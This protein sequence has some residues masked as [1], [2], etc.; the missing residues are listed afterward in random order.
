MRSFA[1][2]GT[3]LGFAVAVLVASWSWSASAVWAETT[4]GQTGDG[5]A[6]ADY[7]V[8]Y[9]TDAKLNISIDGRLDEA[10][11]EKIQPF[12]DHRVLEPETLQIPPLKTK[13]HITHSER[14]LYVG[15]KLFQPP[16][17]NYRRLTNRDSRINRDEVHI[18]IDNSGSGLYGHWFSIALGDSL[19]DGTVLPERNFYHEWDAVWRG[20]SVKTD[21]G[22]SA[23]MFIPWNLIPAAVTENGIARM[24]FYTS[25]KVGYLDERYGFPGLSTI[26]P[27]FM[28]ALQGIRLR[29]PTTR[30]GISLQPFV[31]AETE[32]VS[33]Q[34]RLR[35][36][37]D[38]HWRP[39]RNL[40]LSASV[41]PDFGTTDSDDVVLNLGALETFFSEQRQF[42]LEGR[43]IFFT[44]PRVRG[45][46]QARSRFLLVNT[47]RI[48]APVYR[49]ELAESGF[50][51]SQFDLVTPTDLYG[52]VRINGQSGDFRYGVLSAFEKTR[53][54][55]LAPTSS[56]EPA[57]QIRQQGQTFSAARGVYE[58]KTSD[59][60]KALGLFATNVTG[61]GREALVAGLDVHLLSK[62][63]ARSLD[64][65]FAYSDTK[66]TTDFDSP[67]DEGK[68][69]AMTVDFQHV[70]MPGFKHSLHAEYFSRNFELNDLGYTRRN[71]QIGT[72]YYIEKN[73]P[74]YSRSEKIDSMKFIGRFRHD[75]NLDGQM[76][77]A[78]Y[79]FNFEIDA[80]N[81]SS[82]TTKFAF[83]PERWEDLLSEG[84]GV[85]RIKDRGFVELSWETDIRKRIIG[86]IE[87]S[88]SF[89]SLGGMSK[90]ISSGLKMRPTDNLNLEISATYRDRNNW[91]IHDGGRNFTTYNAGN[92]S[93]S[94]K[95]DIFINAR[96]QF[97]TSLNWVGVDATQ[98]RYYQTPDKAGYLLPVAIDPAAT[99]NR[100]FIVSELIWQ[101]KYRWEFAPLSEL[102]LVY[103]HLSDIDDSS[104]TRF[105]GLFNNAINQPIV[106]QFI[107]KVRYR[108]DG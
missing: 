70:P 83:F 81:T 53:D 91:L 94:F 69:V 45:D 3:K 55:E 4:T 18:T 50:T 26:H 48:G 68:G 86:T 24:G 14:G 89:E 102:I 97:S 66:D 44:S 54:V 34:D 6:G 2:I 65:Q 31:S 63:G 87:A 64:A 100:N 56:T 106:K 104:D 108:F 41:T 101:T 43:S 19:S 99:T 7:D 20:V 30:Q 103:N 67:L 8:L 42:F 84:N 95:A 98:H 40:L 93:L 72:I 25:R 33:K 46:Y 47:R 17:K 10:I 52:A 77:R 61:H 29:V 78:G 82:L 21:Y 5:Q 90:K 105:T 58:K 85:F 79:V 28:S 60:Y 38:L 36:G 22:W 96:N 76:S 59:S 107:L 27:K 92:L 9:R 1:R 88:L 49:G 37:I 16:E 73:I 39:N 32:D 13:V 71:N 80:P 57:R 62:G 23:E 12:T 35:G 11:W 75:W 15:F 74:N 51:E